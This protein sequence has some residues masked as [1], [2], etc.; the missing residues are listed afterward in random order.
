ADRKLLKRFE[1]SA[2]PGRVD[3]LVRYPLVA[4]VAYESKVSLTAG[5]FNSSGYLFAYA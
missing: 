2:A 4:L 3:D 5:K 1:P